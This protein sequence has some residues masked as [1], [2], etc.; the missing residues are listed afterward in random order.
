MNRT[1]VE[2]QAVE[3]D[4]GRAREL[5]VIAGCFF[6]YGAIFFDRLAPLYLVGFIAQDLGV[7]T[8]AQG[9]LA[10]LIGLGWAAAMPILRATAGRIDD[11][12]R[13]VGAAMFAGLCSL[14]SAAAGSWV[15]FVL[16]RGLGGVA[17]GSGSPAITG[18]TFATAP[19]PRR[20]S[21]L[22]IVQSATRIVG[23]LVSPVVVTAVTVAVGWRPAIVVSGAL[24]LVGA[25]VTRVAVP[26]GSLRHGSRPRA[27]PFSLRPGGRRNTALCTVACVLLLTW[28]TVWSQSSVPLVRSWLDLGPDAAGRLV[29]LFG[30]GSGAAA[31]L[32]PLVSDWLGRR[33]ALAVG[34]LLGGA[35]GVAVGSLAAT[36]TVPP[37][38]AVVS[39][40][41]LCGVSMG[42]LPLVISIIPAEAVATGDVG[43][44]LLGPI[45]WG[46]VVGAAAL[47]AAVAAAAVPLGLP[48]V[49][50]LTGA[51]VIGLVPISVLLRP[52]A[53][54]EGAAHIQRGGTP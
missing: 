39:L 5:S 11:R 38:A 13:V 2:A 54:A 41:L 28:L 36:G 22:G 3:G 42:G 30:V 53:H 6:T 24:L 29:G 8:T 51:G 17:A 12:T 14:A 31:L 40:L 19:A 49:I 4:R 47:P 43:R 35:G 23:S 52:L 50:L 32:V 1:G 16:L 34:S 33:G 48:A 26:G 15:V 9:T 10:L 45:A 37:R 7:P 25:V 21:Y 20:G 27:E 44:A 46:E 18:I